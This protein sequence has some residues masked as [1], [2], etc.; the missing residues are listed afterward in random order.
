VLSM[1]ESQNLPSLRRL[2]R[3]RIAIVGS[4]ASAL[5]ALVTFRA[6]GLAGDDLAIYG[7]QPAALHNI[8][9]YTHA[10]KQDR[11][12]SESSGHFFPS[13]FP[14]LA[15]LESLRRRT[16]LPA[17]RSLFDA[18]QPRLDDL[19]AHGDAV[20]H[21]VG[22]AEILTCVRVGRIARDPRDWRAGFVLFD[23]SGRPLGAARHVLLALG[24]PALR[25]PDPLRDVR[26][27]PL[28]SKRGDPLVVHAYQPKT[29]RAGE[30][31]IILGGGMAAAHEWLAALRTGCHVTAISRRPPRR[32]P[33][34]A[35]RCDFTAVG[36]S[37][38]RRLDSAGRHA[39]LDKLSS[40]SFPWR[41][42][43]ERELQEAQHQGRWRWLEAGVVAAQAGEDGL[44]VSLSTG[45]RLSAQRMV[46][47]TGFISDVG[48][49]P[50]L[51]HLMRDYQAPVERGRLIIN[52]DFTLPLSGHTAA[53]L[54]VIGTLARWALPTADT[55]A[56]MKYVA[57]RLIRT[58]GVPRQPAH[59][60]QYSLR[61]CLAT[62]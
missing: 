1:T 60:L 61:L 46:C 14:G 11:M 30:R 52:D 58:L 55:F 28:S 20:A 22:M 53:R 54:A 29:Y 48:S 19:L 4:G 2:R 39:Y 35:P 38:Y 44:N 16:L 31:V 26:G 27:E 8:R 18:Y 40:G 50:L 32:Q 49:H 43:W 37:R 5:V 17:L 42:G 59:R 15:L 7:D 23:E 36:V 57:R 34:N 13:D 47:A 45:E 10:I 21:A 25:W 62:S 6:E 12:R 51:A 56:G 3:S 41:P 24:H 9:S 33:L